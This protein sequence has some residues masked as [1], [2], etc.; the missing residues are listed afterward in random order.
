MH[1][2]PGKD[3]CPRQGSGHRFLWSAVVACA[4]C[5]NSV[6]HQVHLPFNS[7]PLG[8]ASQ[9]AAAMQPETKAMMDLILKKDFTLS[10]ALDGGSLV[11][12]YPYDKPVQ[13]GNDSQ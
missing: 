7:P 13:S 3:Q 2:P 10:V 4:F 8:N 5:K 11:A 6:L 9:Q 12:T 1:V